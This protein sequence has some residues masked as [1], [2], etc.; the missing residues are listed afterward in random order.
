[1]SQSTETNHAQGLKSLLFVEMPPT[2]GGSRPLPGVLEEGS[3]IRDVCAKKY[4]FEA[5]K[6]PTADEVLEEMTKSKVVP[7]AWQGSSDPKVASNS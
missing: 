2:P 1:M 5:R 3:I 6:H 4:I 7:F